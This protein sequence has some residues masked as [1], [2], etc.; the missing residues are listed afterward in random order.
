MPFS[1]L[2]APSA[3]P[4]ADD[5]CVVIQADRL[6]VAT[7]LESGVSFPTYAAL[8]NW[9]AP[10]GVPLHLGLM[11][12][13][14]C[15]LWRVENPEAAP[16]AGWQWQDTR[17]LVGAFTPAQAHAVSCARQLLW[18][19]Q[20]HQFCGVCGTPTIEMAEERARRCPKCSAVFFPVASPAIIVAVTRGEEL[21]LAHNRN[22]RAGMF[23]LLAGFVDPGETLEQAVVRE[24]R[25]EVGIDVDDLRYVTSQPWPFPNSLMLGFRARY[26]AG[27][28][29]VDGKEIEQAGWYARNAMPEV[30]RAGTV[31]RLLIDQWRDGKL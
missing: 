13:R 14:V 7:A 1:H 27:E 28:I 31:A 6:L 5:V 24:V 4:A 10:R 29:K 26:V 20:R 11:E 12:S 18:W 17:T 16:P 21:L 19:D 25:E 15:W 22:F 2:H 3:S 30:P 23:S 8:V 9:G